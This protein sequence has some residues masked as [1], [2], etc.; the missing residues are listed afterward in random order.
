MKKLNLALVLAGALT[1]SAQAQSAVEVYGIVDMGVAREFGNVLSSTIAHGNKITSGA[2]SGTRLGFKGKEDLGNGLNALFVLETGI[3][4]DAGGF[5]Q[6]NKAFGRQSFLGLQGDFGTLTLGRQYTSYF[7]TLNQ[8]ADPFASGL[9]G[10]AQN[11]MLPNS[12]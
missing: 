2:Q 8:V 7:L 6:A 11:L 10:N 12:T 1:G 4:A 5:N 3:A 9:A